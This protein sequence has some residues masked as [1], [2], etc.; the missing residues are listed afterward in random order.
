MAV[1]GATAPYL[2][3]ELSQSGRGAVFPWYLAAT[4]LVSLVVYVTARET[5]RSA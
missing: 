3:T 1:F 2:V 4:C 5:A